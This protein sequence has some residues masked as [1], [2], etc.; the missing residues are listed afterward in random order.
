MSTIPHRRPLPQWPPLRNRSCEDFA[1]VWRVRIVGTNQ[2]LANTCTSPPPSSSIP[3]RPRQP[4]DHPN[5]AL[6]LTPTPSC[7][8][9]LPVM[10]LSSPLGSPI[11]DVMFRRTVAAMRRNSWANLRRG[12]LQRLWCANRAAIRPLKNK[13][14]KNID[15]VQVLPPLRNR[16]SN[17]WGRYIWPA[18]HMSGLRLC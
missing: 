7:R 15:L 18:R 2:I 4:R 6:R 10:V 16:R 1:T 12:T 5:I 13:M 3:A 8:A 9:E 11:M 17:P 14:E